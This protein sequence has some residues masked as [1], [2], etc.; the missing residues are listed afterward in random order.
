M[1]H[2]F[3]DTPGSL[4]LQDTPGY[5]CLCYTAIGAVLFVAM[6][7]LPFVVDL[8]MAE[9]QRLTTP[10]QRTKMVAKKQAKADNMPD[11]QAFENAV[12]TAFPDKKQAD[13]L[14][15]LARVLYE[16]DK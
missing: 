11:L 12:D 13:I 14:K 2:K 9:P 6:L 5:R 7:L 10:Q 1:Q 3:L 8:A 16:L 15:K 4:M